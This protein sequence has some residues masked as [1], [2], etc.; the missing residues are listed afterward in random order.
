MWSHHTS[1]LPVIGVERCKAVVIKKFHSFSWLIPLGF[2]QETRS[3][4]GKTNLSHHE[5]NLWVP[6]QP[7][8]S[9]PLKFKRSLLLP[10]Y[11]FCI[12]KNY[13]YFWYKIHIFLIQHATNRLWYGNDGKSSIWQ[14]HI[15]HIRQ[16]KSWKGRM[17]AGRM[18]WSPE[19]ENVP[20]DP[21]L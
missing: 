16:G 19:V 17:W 8:Y 10:F 12:S 3:V 21:E 5:A 6:S 18:K 14:M 9:L 11:S 2:G 20:L 4:V 7:E 1:I 13:A 15:Y